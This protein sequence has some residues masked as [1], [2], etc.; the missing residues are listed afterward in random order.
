MDS[1]LWSYGVEVGTHAVRMILGKVRGLPEEAAAEM[2]NRM[3]AGQVK[4]EETRQG[5]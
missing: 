2:V 1:A 4:I 3:R 5:G